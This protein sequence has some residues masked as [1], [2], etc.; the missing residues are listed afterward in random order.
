MRF[1]ATVGWGVVIYA[2]MALSW[3]LMSTY[4]ISGTLLSRILELVVL[5]VTTTIAGRSLHLHA[6]RDI[7]PYS[8]AWTAVAFV[9]DALLNVPLIGWQLFADWNVWIGYALVVVVPLFSPQTRAIR[10][11]P[12]RRAH[13]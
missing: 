12:H 13:L 10:E 11:T 7:L 6:W 3:S 1:G 9:I 5:V 4:S 8:I 2:I